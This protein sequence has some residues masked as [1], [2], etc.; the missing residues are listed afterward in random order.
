MSI[1][2][3]RTLTSGLL[4]C[5]AVGALA[6]CASPAPPAA[7]LSSETPVSAPWSFASGEQ[8]ACDAPAIK[9]RI[10]EALALDTETD[11]NSTLSP[12]SEVRAAG[13]HDAEVEYQE[14][15]WRDLPP[16]DRLFKLCFAV[17]QGFER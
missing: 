14:A 3:L 2:P 5:A 17:Q 10:R 13:R 7:T 12:P 15:V 11:E 6:A 9:D 1:T 4:I 16:S 8:K